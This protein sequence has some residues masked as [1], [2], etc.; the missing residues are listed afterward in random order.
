[1]RCYVLDPI[2]NVS[3]MMHHIRDRLMFSISAADIIRREHSRKNSPKKIRKS[4]LIVNTRDDACFS[5]LLT[6]GS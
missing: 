6:V 2:T 4:R 5:H 1:M 3:V